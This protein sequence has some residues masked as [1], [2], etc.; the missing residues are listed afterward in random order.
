MHLRKR[1]VWTKKEEDMLIMAFYDIIAQGWKCDNGIYK[2]G[3]L[4]IYAGLV[5]ASLI[6]KDT[7]SVDVF[8][9]LDEWDLEAWVRLLL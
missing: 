8:L 9:S 2:A 4:F 7:S 6:T 5:A 1:R 3:I